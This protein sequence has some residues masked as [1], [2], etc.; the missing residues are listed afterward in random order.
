LLFDGARVYFGWN[1][2]MRATA[3][4]VE[5]EVLH[6]FKTFLAA[7]NLTDALDLRLKRSVDR[8]CLFTQ[9]D[10][11]TLYIA[12]LIRLTEHAALLDVTLPREAHK[13]PRRYAYPSWKT[14]TAANTI[15]AAIFDMGASIAEMLGDDLFSEIGVSTDRIRAALNAAH[16]SPGQ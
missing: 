5:T 1:A 4:D 6:S 15:M 3:P 10:A 12:Y 9:R 2:L 13:C 8:Q 11:L 14:G 7:A 16:I